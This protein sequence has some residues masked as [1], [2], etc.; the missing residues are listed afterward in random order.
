M[1]AV[2]RFFRTFSKGELLLW[3]ASVLLI[4]VSF[5][6][7]DRENWLTLIAS[8]V[9]AT[10]LIF[11]AKGNPAGQALMLLFSALYGVISWTFSYYGEMTTSAGM[12]APRRRWPCTAG[13]PPPVRATPA[14]SKSNRL[15]AGEAV[16]ASLLTAAVTAGFYFIL[17]ALHTANLIPSTVSVATSFLAVYLTFRR[18]PYYALAYAA[19]DV[20]LIVLWTLAAI[21]DL[22]Y[23]SVIICFVM[24]LANDLYGFLNWRKMQKK[25]AALEAAEAA[26]RAEATESAETNGAL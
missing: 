15:R 3:G 7:F 22:S 14:E 19:N 4:A 17:K 13:P 1:Q 18:S 21:E 11:C 6:A 8:L 10:S 2:K 5:C 23:L 12:P 24:F 26:E 16:F 25:Q 9:G 20:V